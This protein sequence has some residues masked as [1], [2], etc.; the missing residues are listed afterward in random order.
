M[1][2]ILID[3]L[4]T[5]LLEVRNS[6]SWRVQLYDFE[7]EQSNVF[8]FWLCNGTADTCESEILPS[9]YFNISNEDPP[10]SSST[11]ILTATSAGPTSATTSSAP[12]TKTATAQDTATTTAAG[13]VNTSNSSTSSEHASGGS[14]IST[15]AGVGIGVGVALA[16]ISAVVCAL[17][18]VRSKRKTGQTH[19]IDHPKAIPGGGFHSNFAHELPG[20]GGSFVGNREKQELPLSQSVPEQEYLYHRQ[21]GQEEPVEIYTEQQRSPVEL[22]AGRRGDE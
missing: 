20:P 18:I 22:N 6:F 4:G 7:L 17:V 1:T 11:S 8:F 12:A 2:I 10:E 13:A 5:S 16:G 14:G 9:P 19:Q 15:G 3:T 21:P